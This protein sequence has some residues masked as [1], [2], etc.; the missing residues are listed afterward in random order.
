LK[1]LI[2]KKGHPVT[3]S[4]IVIRP[5]RKEW[6]LE[7]LW[8]ILNSP[9]ANAYIYCY[10]T[11][12]LVGVTRVLSFPIPNMNEND[13]SY[14]CKLV[15]NYFKIFPPNRGILQSEV[16]SKEAKQKILAIDAEVM[17]LYN[18]PPRL[19]RQVLDLFDG[20]QRNGVDFKFE[21]YFPKDFESWIP[22]HEYLSKDYQRSTT[23]FV[24][25]WV[26]DVRSPDV[27]G[28]FKA[29]EEA[30]KED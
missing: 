22:L 20:W 12:R 7:V 25:Q 13:F 2:D 26:E 10:G 15:H 19:E 24:N 21:R 28:A 23:P 5:K 6:S 16:D 27:I 29:A 3:S 9:L 8:A 14:L 30:F 11:K 4:F 18:L 1:A 17:R